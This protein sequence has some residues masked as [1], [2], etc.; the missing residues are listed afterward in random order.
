MITGSTM[1]GIWMAGDQSSPPASRSSTR[2]SRVSDSLAAMT[3]PALPAP[4]TM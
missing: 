4:T 2:R 3:A 1:P